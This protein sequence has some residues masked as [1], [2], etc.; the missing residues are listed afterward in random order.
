MEEGKKLSIPELR[1]MK[2]IPNERIKPYSAESY[3]AQYGITLEEAEV[4]IESHATHREI[5]RRIYAMFVADPA[6]KHRALFIDT[7][8]DRR[9]GDE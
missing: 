6:L 5:E 7:A 4:L 9:D 1:G 8:P 2:P 3:S